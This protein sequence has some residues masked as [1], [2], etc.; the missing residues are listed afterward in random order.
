MIAIIAILIALLLPTLSGAKERAQRTACLNNLKQL[1]LCWNLYVTD[2]GGKVVPNNFVFTP[3]GD[4][5][6][7]DVTWCA[8]LA[9]YDTDTRFIQNGA[10]W[11]YNKSAAI[12]RCPTDKSKVRDQVTGLETTQDRNRSYNMNGT[13]GCTATPWI[14]AYTRLEQM[15]RPGPSGIFIFAE[16]HED[17]ILDSHFG[18]APATN[19]YVFD[20]NKE[21]RTWGEIPADRHNRGAQFSFADGH[22]EYWKWATKK[23][24]GIWGRTVVNDDELRDLRRV[25]RAICPG[26]SEGV[27]WFY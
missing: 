5:I 13:V 17:C 23:S 24:P 10:L 8:G 27:G 15:K 20:Q 19:P 12:Y 26:P 1:Q 25:Q 2:S 22:V 18:A 14:S 21:Q 4:P 11:N 16:V 6:E 9:P 7:R 3:T